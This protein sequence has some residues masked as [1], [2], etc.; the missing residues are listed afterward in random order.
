[1]ESGQILDSQISASSEYDSWHS[2]QNGRLNFEDPDKPDAWAPKSSSGSWL[3]VDFKIQAIITEVLTQ[4]RKD[5][6]QWVT[7]YTLSYTNNSNEF[8]KYF[9]NGG[10]KVTELV[11]AYI[12]AR[13]TM[14]TPLRTALH[15]APLLHRA[16]HFMP[17]P[18]HLEY[19]KV[20]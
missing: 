20:G 18:A 19:S 16:L 15:T 12:C 13:V 10:E 1:M 14:S 7:E 2:A 9:E 4:G 5:D 11:S 17:W 8:I 3:Q 6:P